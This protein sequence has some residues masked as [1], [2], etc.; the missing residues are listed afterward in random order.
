MS[1]CL[2]TV[3]YHEHFLSRRFYEDT[4]KVRVSSCKGE[5]INGKTYVVIVLIARSSTHGKLK[6]ADKI[7]ITLVYFCTMII[8]AGFIESTLSLCRFLF[9]RVSHRIPVRRSINFFLRRKLSTA[10]TIVSRQHFRCS[11][12]SFESA[13]K[14]TMFMFDSNVDKPQVSFYNNLQLRCAIS[15]QFTIVHKLQLCAIRVIYAA[16]MILEKC[17]EKYNTSDPITMDFV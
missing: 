6:F 16:A 9:L 14:I 5:L 13:R 17:S 15:I 10:S 11:R 7:H 8:S 1:E 3:A 2:Q 12:N 4:Q